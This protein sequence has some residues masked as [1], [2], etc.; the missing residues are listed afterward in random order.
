M[1]GGQV[2][3][4]PILGSWS[5]DERSGRTPRQWNVAEAPVY[6]LDLYNPWSVDNGRPWVPF[7]DK[8]TLAED[9]AAGRPLLVGEY[10]CRTDPTQAR[11]SRDMDARRVRH[12]ARRGCHRDGLLQL[13]SELT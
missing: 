7:A 10:G 8:L 9:E 4:V 6:G 3:V 12:G 11:P 5:F 1:A 2:T 13:V